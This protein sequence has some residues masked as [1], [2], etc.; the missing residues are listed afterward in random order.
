MARAKSEHGPD[1]RADHCGHNGPDSERHKYLQESPDKNVPVHREDATDD[2]RCN[3]EVEKVGRLRKLN[4]RRFDLGRDQMIV[5]KSG[6]N[7]SR[8]NRAGTNIAQKREPLA[9]LCTGEAAH[10]KHH[11][12]RWAVGL[13]L[14]HG[15]KRSDQSYEQDI[16]RQRDDADP[17]ID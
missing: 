3:E 17:E 12:H 13:D 4:D 15:D 2:D 14:A 9:D 10:D 7:K 5:G 16:D 11:D 6:R 8:E 1:Q